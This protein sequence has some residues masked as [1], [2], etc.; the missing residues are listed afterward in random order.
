MEMWFEIWY[1][2][3]V[4]RTRVMIWSNHFILNDYSLK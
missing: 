1:P 2:Q 4:C 3:Q